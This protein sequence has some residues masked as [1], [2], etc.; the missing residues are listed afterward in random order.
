MR[1]F[2]GKL[3]F[4]HRA[5]WQ[6]DAAY[7]WAVLLGPPPLLGCALAA[8]VWAVVLRMAPHAVATAQAIPWAHWVRPTLQEGQPFVETPSGPLPSTDASGHFAGFRTGWVGLIQ[9]ITVDAALDTHVAPTVLARFAVDQTT[10][11]LAQVLDAGAPSGLFVGTAK[12]FFAATT[13]GLYAFS[14]RFTRSSPQS[15]DCLVWLETPKHRM[16][17]N[18]NL[19]L[20][21]QAV[22]NFVPTAFELQP[23]LFVLEVAVGCWR[24]DRMVG[25]GELTVMVR[26]PGETGLQPARDDELIKPLPPAVRP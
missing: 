20:N 1:G 23:G 9:P 17:R 3:G 6:R 10:I 15:A 14:A 24:G 16:V 11:S 2:A 5:L 7:R 4:V 22:L 19:N 12:T 26:H 8:L 18:V 21:G 13:P 25:P